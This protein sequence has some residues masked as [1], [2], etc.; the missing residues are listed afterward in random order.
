MPK[1]AT[2]CCSLAREMSTKWPTTCWS[3]ESRWLMARQRM[4]AKTGRMGSWFRTLGRWTV[5]LCALAMLIYA[6]LDLLDTAMKSEMFM[7]EDVAVEGNCMVSEDDILQ[8]LDIPSVI[9]LWQIDPDLLEV[10]LGGLTAVRR[11]KVERVFP[12]SLSVSVEERVPI[13]DWQ[14]PK[15]GKRFA[16]DEEGVILA[17]SDE[18]KARG[19]G[20]GI[21]RWAQ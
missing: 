7:V 10:R 17:E 4:R 21:S 5:A 12:Q 8:A 15:S 6:G 18:L 20:G 3:R 19:V 11:A 14:D 13:V 1:R 9:H 16:V 2:P